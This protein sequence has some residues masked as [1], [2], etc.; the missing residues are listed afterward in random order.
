MKY[1]LEIL[2]CRAPLKGLFKSEA[3][4]EACGK[5]LKIKNQKAKSLKVLTLK[6]LD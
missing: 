4:L 2:K 6:V 3:S 1:H 5:S